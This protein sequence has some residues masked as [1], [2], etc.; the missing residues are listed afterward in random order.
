MIFS[1]EERKRWPPTK[2]D[3]KIG[4]RVKVID[5]GGED[6]GCRNYLGLIGTVVGG[7]SNYS[8]DYFI[9]DFEGELSC[10]FYAEELRP[11]VDGEIS[12]PVPADADLTS[13]GAKAAIIG[14]MKAR[15]TLTEDLPQGKVPS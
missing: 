15:P 12:W 9:L 1:E 3:Y 14:I 11:A 10:G 2:R 7:Y 6:G 5:M 8:T 4:D 13:L